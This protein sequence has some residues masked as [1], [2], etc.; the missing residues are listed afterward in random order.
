MGW[1]G[2]FVTVPLGHFSFC[3]IVLKLGPAFLSPLDSSL[4]IVFEEQCPC[5]KR[6]IVTLEDA[7]GRSSVMRQL[8]SGLSNQFS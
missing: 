7:K 1:P 6:C 5:R 8:T 3:G 4:L 2:F